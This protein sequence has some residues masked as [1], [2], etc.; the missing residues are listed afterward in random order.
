MTSALTRSPCILCGNRSFATAIPAL[1]AAAGQD[2]RHRAKYAVLECCNCSLALLD[3]QPEEPTLQ[4][5]YPPSYYAHQPPEPHPTG[6][7]RL[8]VHRLPIGA[9]PAGGRLLD[10]G[11]GSGL[12]LLWATEL[13]WDAEGIEIN[14]TAVRYAIACGLRVRQGTID[15]VAY[16]DNSFDVVTMSHSLEHIRQPVAVLRSVSRMLRP[17]GKLYL[18]TPNRGGMLAK[19]AGRRWRQLDIPRHLYFL[20]RV[21]LGRMLDQCGFSVKRVWTVTK[22]GLALA[23]I[24]QLAF[25]PPSKQPLLTESSLCKLAALPVCRLLDALGRGDELWAEAIASTNG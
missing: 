7:R 16:S 19:V 23:T 11:C 4:A 13:G 6:I 1:G 12:F 25:I 18:S 10:V 9:A 8:F 15:E 24:C 22:P 5:T 20:T 3:P 21:T 14:A 17:G 2:Q